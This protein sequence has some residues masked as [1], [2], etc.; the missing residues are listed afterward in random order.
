[1]DHIF[2]L[3]QL[4]FLSSGLA[5][6][7]LLWKLKNHPPQKALL[8][9]AIF[10]SALTLIVIT[11]IVLSY[12]RLNFPDFNPSLQ[13]L[14]LILEQIPRVVALMSAIFFTA[15]LM[16]NRFSRYVPALWLILLLLPLLWQGLEGQPTIQDGAITMT[17]GILAMN[18]SQLA[19]LIFS[20]LLAFLYFKADESQPLSKMIRFWIIF[21]LCSL[22][23]FALDFILYPHILSQ[24]LFQIPVLAYYRV[25]YIVL[26]SSVLIYGLKSLFTP[27]SLPKRSTDFS[28]NTITQLLTAREAEILSLLLE[29][30]AYKYIGTKLGISVNTVKVHIY[31]IYQKT[32]ASN[33]VELQYMLQNQE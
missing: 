13:H 6:V 20:I 25:Y 29:G 12:L 31:N 2:I 4:I 8:S 33:R 28:T 22:P 19:G 15:S 10:L 27:T 23:G 16:S 7:F 1:M 5:S 9:Y 14:I 30:S 3:F 18:L 17:S 26:T 21:S 32:G 11:N 24:G